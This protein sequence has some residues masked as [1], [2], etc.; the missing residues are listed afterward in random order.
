[1][2]SKVFQLCTGFQF[3][4]QPD[5]L[6]SSACPCVSRSVAV[7]DRDFPT[8]QRASAAS[9]SKS[10]CTAQPRKLV[11]QLIGFAAES[12]FYLTPKL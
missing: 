3:L 2:N 10:G 6:C 1:M 9:F 12:F 5:G 7:F 11:S 8:F 4:S